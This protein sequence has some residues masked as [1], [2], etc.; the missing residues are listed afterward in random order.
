MAEHAQA[1]ALAKRPDQP[2]AEAEEE[3]LDQAGLLA[4]RAQESWPVM[5]KLGELVRLLAQLRPPRPPSEG[6]WPMP[7]TNGRG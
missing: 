6:Q 5:E 7:Q 1:V 3:K 4:V 2:P